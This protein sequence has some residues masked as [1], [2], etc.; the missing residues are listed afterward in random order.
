[1]VVGNVQYPEEVADAVSASWRR[2]RS[3]SARTPKSEIERKERTKREVQAQGIANAMQI[4]RGQLSA[5]CIQHE[6]DRGA[7]AMVS[8]PEPHGGL[9]PGRADGR[10]DHGTFPTTGRDEVVLGALSLALGP[11][12]GPRFLW[13][14]HGPRTGRGTDYRTT[15]GRSDRGP[16]TKDLARRY[17]LRPCRHSFALLVMLAAQDPAAT[18][19][20]VDVPTVD[21]RG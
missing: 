11:S 8:S 10:A 12:S 9:H 19:G 18:V 13:G 21:S 15:D 4:I 20:M 2:R 3:C 16:A 1:M 17:I 14:P 7:E 5:M 6:A